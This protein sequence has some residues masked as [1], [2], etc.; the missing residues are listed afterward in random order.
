MLMYQLVSEVHISFS[1]PTKHQYFYHPTM[2]KPT[3]LNCHT[4]H[5]AA[6]YTLLATSGAN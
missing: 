2:T 3:I 6:Y 5:K 4:D 1:H